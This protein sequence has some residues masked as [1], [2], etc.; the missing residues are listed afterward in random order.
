MHG[1]GQRAKEFCTLRRT[2][3]TVDSTDGTAFWGNVD[4]TMPFSDT[5]MSKA[6]C[7]G[8]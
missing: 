7:L 6:S 8:K 1:G 4:G 2:S 3:D 5:W